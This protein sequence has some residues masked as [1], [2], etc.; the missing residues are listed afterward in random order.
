MKRVGMIIG[1]RPEKIEEYKRLHA[2]VW[3]EVLQGLAGANIRNISI[4]LR[5]PENLMVM[6]WEYHGDDYEADMAK[7]AE[8]DATKRWWALFERI[9]V[10]LES[11][12]EGEH[13]AAMEEIFHHD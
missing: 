1:I 8:Q 11:R 6:T 9:Q 5:Q 13:W 12:A 4:F 7:L 10:P 2:D 3:P